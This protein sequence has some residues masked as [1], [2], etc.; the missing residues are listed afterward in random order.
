MKKNTLLSIWI[1]LV[2]LTI[3]TALI[4][5]IELKNTAIVIL[6]LAFI[7]IISVVFYFMELKKAHSFWKFLFVT[8]LTSQMLVIIWLVF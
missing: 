4:T 6:F 3:I 8:F 5:K 2:A 7:K 1:V